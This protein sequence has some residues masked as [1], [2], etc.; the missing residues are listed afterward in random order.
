MPHTCMMEQLCMMQLML[1]TCML[2]ES[3]AHVQD[4]MH[5]STHAYTHA[6]THTSSH[7]CTHVGNERGGGEGREGRTLL[8]DAG[9]G[10][11]VVVVA[12]VEAEV[13]GPWWRLALGCR[14]VNRRRV[15]GGNGAGGRRGSGINAKK[16][17]AQVSSH[18]PYVA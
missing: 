4:S 17:W 7:V 11:K 2:M 13:A 18:C 9:L 6:G 8:Q 10:R 5:N 15:G 14:G 1:L 3:D 16:L 12:K